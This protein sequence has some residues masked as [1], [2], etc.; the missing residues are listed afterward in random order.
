MQFD[1]DWNEQVD[2]HAYQMRVMQSSL[3]G[4]GTP[5]ASAGFKVGFDTSRGLTLSPGRYIVGGLVI[6]SCPPARPTRASAQRTKTAVFHRHPFC[7][8]WPRALPGFTWMC[9]RGM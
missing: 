2:I 7:L 4:D 9:G 1:A 5:R 8:E 6:A 3:F